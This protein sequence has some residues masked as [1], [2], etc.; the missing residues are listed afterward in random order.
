MTFIS[1]AQNYEDV[2]L[3]RALKHIKEGFYID[4]GAA[5]PDTD[6]VTKAFY[7]AGWHGINIDP[8]P[9]FIAQLKEQ[10]NKDVNLM[11]AISDYEGDAVIHIIEDTGLSTLCKDIAKSHKLSGF[12][13]SELGIVVTTL[14]KVCEEYVPAEQEIHFLKVDVE[15]LEESV[16][17]G[18]DWHKFR[19]WVLVVE[20]T[21]PMSQVRSY[22]QWQSILIDKGYKFAYSDGLNRFYVDTNHEELLEKFE[23]PPNIFDGFILNS[24]AKIEAKSYDLE[25]QLQQVAAKLEHSEAKSYDLEKQLQQVAAKLE[26]SEAKSYDLEKQLQQV[27]AKLEHSEAKSYDLEKQ[28]QQVAAKLEHSEAKSYDLE[29]QLQQ[30]AAKLEHSEA[31]S[32][33]LEKQLQQVAAKLEHSEAKSYDLEKQLQQVAAKLEHSEAKSYD[34]EKQLQQVAAKLEHSEAKSYDLEKQLQQVA[35]KLEHSEAKSYDLEKQ[36]QQVELISAEYEHKLSQSNL[37]LEFIN[38]VLQ[39]TEQL[40]YQN[41]CAAESNYKQLQDVF[42]S[43]SWRLTKPIR[44][45]SYQIRQLYTDGLL[46]RLR[47]FI[48]KVL[49]KIDYIL[50]LQP[51]LR[52]Q[53]IELSK[54]FGLHNTL[55]I[56]YLKAHNH[57]IHIQPPFSSTYQ[58]APSNLDSLSPRA[59]KSLCAL[60]VGDRANKKEG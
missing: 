47:A 58:L 20:A 9:K 1:Y 59:K 10:R 57:K 2:M 22:N 43:R 5:W 53:L 14:A 49:R 51:T 56:I 46:F 4:V 31:K 3:W 15:G 17:R 16:L 42:A 8:N 28:L 29:K 35:A 36:L 32:Y 48:K 6:S 18:N 24:E 34:L 54:K 45:I 21:L 55:R 27:A 19:P 23:Y 26:H 50:L 44:W 41:W 60:K 37:E 39:R 25:K 30:V 38:A 12:K 11:V 40:N 52:R 33:D 13:D 7:N